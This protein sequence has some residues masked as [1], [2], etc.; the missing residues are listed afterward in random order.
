MISVIVLTTLFNVGEISALPP[1][2][3]KIEARRRGKGQK[4]RR[5]GGNGLR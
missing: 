5:R 4:S 3:P 1:E 2:G